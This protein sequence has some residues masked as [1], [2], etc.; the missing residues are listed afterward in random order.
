M[1][2]GGTYTVRGDYFR[3]EA[4]QVDADGKRF[5][6]ND[7]PL[8][9]NNALDPSLYVIEGVDSIEDI[10]ADNVVYIYKNANNKI[11]RI[12]V[13]T[14]T[15]SGTVTNVNAADSTRTLGG[16]VLALAPYKGQNREGVDTPGNEGTAL[17]DIYGRIFDFQLGEASKGN[18]AVVVGKQH[19]ASWEGPGTYN[20]KIFDKTGKEVTYTL[21]SDSTVKYDALNIG[22]LIEYTLSGGK[23]QVTKKEDGLVSA[24]DNN[25]VSASGAILNVNGLSSGIL[26]DSSNVL[27]YVYEEVSKT[28]GTP[29]YTNISLSSLNDLK[30]VELNAGPLHYII[31]GSS[32]KV[33]AILVSIKNA[34]AQNVF[35]M[36]NSIDDSWNEDNRVDYVNGLDFSKGAG[37]EATNW[38]F[39]D[40]SLNLKWGRGSHATMVK[41]RI[42]ENG[43]LKSAEELNT[44]T[45]TTDTPVNPT[46][47][48]TFVA[49]TGGSS[50]SFAITTTPSGFSTSQNL[51]FASNAVLY[52]YESNKWVAYRPTDG[53]FK[54]DDSGTT[55][56][57]L[58]TD[59]DKDY[60]VIIKQKP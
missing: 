9:V 5:N 13:G 40:N 52:K 34:G 54:A 12:D 28:P 8:D 42:D 43:V 41:F 17:L 24:S 2:N 27:V 58:K 37:V 57:F 59:P 11:T 19:D 29:D 4:G 1:A 14:E 22:D 36:I 18:F 44:I 49:W 7:F 39:T 35:V 3:Y 20:V 26:I 21:H 33:K 31:D 30:D 16:K 50:G 53:N 10:A 25:K 6:G 56:E 47:K 32:E 38:Y 45:T 15:Q 60:D 48:G 23:L 55:Y 46:V 51:A